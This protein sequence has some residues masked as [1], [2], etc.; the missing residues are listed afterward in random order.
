MYICFYTS[1]FGFMYDIYSPIYMQLPSKRAGAWTR[2]II[3]AHNIK[4]REHCRQKIGGEYLEKR[5]KENK[6]K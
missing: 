4:Q 3:E 5:K 6:I 1:E 2:I